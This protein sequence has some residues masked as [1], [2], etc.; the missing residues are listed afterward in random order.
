MLTD[1]EIVDLVRKYRE[2]VSAASSLSDAEWLKWFEKE[3]RYA[4]GRDVD[5][6]ISRMHVLVTTSEF[7][8]HYSTIMDTEYWGRFSK[9]NAEYVVSHVGKESETV[10]RRIEEVLKAT[11]EWDA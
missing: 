7:H 11:G 9:E 2:D 8:K 5:E 4:W 3:V 1:P 6:R 10:L